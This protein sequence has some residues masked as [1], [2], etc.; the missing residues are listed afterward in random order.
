MTNEP[1]FVDANVLVYAMDADA[2]QHA[3]SRAL[4]KSAREG[5]VTLYVTSQILCEFYSVVTN[6]KRVPNPRS[7]EDAVDAISRLLIYLRVLPM[8]IGTENLWLDLLRRHPV[9]GPKVYQKEC[10]LSKHGVPYRPADCGSHASQRHPANLYLQHR[11]LPSILRINCSG[12]IM[13][14]TDGGA[15]GHSRPFRVMPHL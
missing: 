9:K 11:R 13:P 3:S 4:L 6:A 7:P 8:P 15:K 14:T 1:G 12:P 2:P 5:F 10:R